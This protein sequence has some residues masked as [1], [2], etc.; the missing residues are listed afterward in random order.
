VDAGVKK[1]WAS[2]EHGMVVVYGTADAYALRR[3]IESEMVRP[4]EIVSGGSPPY[5]YPVA[6]AA[7]YYGPPLLPAYGGKGGAPQ[8]PPHAYAWANP[9]PY[10]YAVQ[11]TVPTC[12]IL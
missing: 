7:P 11:S 8:P 2:P 3:R 10:G 6:T 9:D 12:T 1:V 5:Y 4:V